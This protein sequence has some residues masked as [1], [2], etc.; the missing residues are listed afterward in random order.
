MASTRELW[1]IYIGQGGVNVRASEINV[2]KRAPNV[3]GCMRWQQ[4]VVV[5]T[6]VQRR[7]G[8]A[9][10][11]WMI[12]S[13]DSLF[14][15]C[16]LTTTTNTGRPSNRRASP[17]PPPPPFPLFACT[18]HSAMSSVLVLP[19][20][21]LLCA[22]LVTGVWAAC[23]RVGGEA[24]PARTRPLC[25]PSLLEFPPPFSHP[26]FNYPSTYPTHLLLPPSCPSYQSRVPLYT[27]CTASP[28]KE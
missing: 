4:C 16:S 24:E 25:L 20:P 9:W 28:V 1:Y 26:L 5:H 7:G 23:L 15:H 22:C 18:G 2:S 6:T 19:M 14:S 21:V 17:L 10:L 13:K 11:A 3:L 27:C 8:E 12:R